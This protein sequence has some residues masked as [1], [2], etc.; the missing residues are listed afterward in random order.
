MGG[1]GQGGE[2]SEGGQPEGMNIVGDPRK[3]G[4]IPAGGQ[5]QGGMP[6]MPPEI[7]PDP[8]GAPEDPDIMIAAEAKEG[9]IRPEMPEGA[10][11]QGGM[12]QPPEKPAGEG[13]AQ[14]GEMPQMPGDG[15]GTGRAADR[16]GFGGDFGRGGAQSSEIYTK[17]TLGKPATCFS[18]IM[19]INL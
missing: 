18:G 9:A 11:Q 8:N 5:P 12:A 7:M 15:F 17:F 13:S 10:G 14:P 3:D 6:D 2:T 16:G 4:E 1:R 19:A